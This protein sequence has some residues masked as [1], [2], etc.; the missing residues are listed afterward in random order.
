[1]LEIRPDNDGTYKVVANGH[2]IVRDIPSQAA[3]DVLIK[4]IKASP[5][6][7][8]WARYDGT[9][10]LPEQLALHQAVQDAQDEITADA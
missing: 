8:D 5:V 1:M 10:W 3:A 7:I 6:A 2:G 4:H 9:L